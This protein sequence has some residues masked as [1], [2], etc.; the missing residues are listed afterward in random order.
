METG[1]AMHFQSIGDIEE[2]EI[3]AVFAG[4]HAKLTNPREPHAGNNQLLLTSGRW[5][6][7][8]EYGVE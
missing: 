4:C 6:R 1:M 8:L 5:G 2:M 3:T 7:V